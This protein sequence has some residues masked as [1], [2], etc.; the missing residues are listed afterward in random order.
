MTYLN[1]ESLHS[2]LL[3]VFSTGKLTV[4]LSEK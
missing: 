2:S 4:V 3:T 1:I